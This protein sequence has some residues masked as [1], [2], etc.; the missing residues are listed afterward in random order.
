MVRGP[1]ANLGVRVR[2]EDDD[3]SG[4][5]VVGQPTLK[6]ESIHARQVDV[7]DETADDLQASRAEQY[8][9][10]REHD[11]TES[12]R[13]EERVERGADTLVVVDDPDDVSLGFH[14]GKLQP[15]GAAADLY[16]GIA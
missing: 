5:T 13:S 4:A 12:G 14:N 11:N 8:L 3:R 16:D 10:R 7:K 9:S 15:M 1:C 2:G 6:T